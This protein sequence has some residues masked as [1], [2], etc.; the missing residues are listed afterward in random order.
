MDSVSIE[1]HIDLR[2]AFYTVSLSPLSIARSLLHRT[3]YYFYF[4]FGTTRCFFQQ[5]LLLL[6]TVSGALLKPWPQSSREER[7]IDEDF[8]EREDIDLQ[9]GDVDEASF[10]ICVGEWTDPG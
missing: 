8:A 4:D 3:P 6:L 1:I 5:Y 9:L 7:A 2:M 10:L